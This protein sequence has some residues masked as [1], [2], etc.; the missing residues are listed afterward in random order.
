VVNPGVRSC[1]SGREPLLLSS[2][3]PCAT[4]KIALVNSESTFNDA[5]SEIQDAIAAADYDRAIALTDD[6][7]VSYPDALGA[8]RV[9]AS[10]FGASGRPFQAAE[11]YAR[12]LDIAP[13]DADAMSKMAMALSASGQ[14]AEAKL[15]ARQALDYEP[16]DAALQRII[17]LPGVEEADC[18]DVGVHLRAGLSDVRAGLLDRGIAR[19]SQAAAQ[20]PDRVDV[21]VALA[22]ALWQSGAQ[23]AAAEV[24]QAILDVQ[25][26]CLNAHA[27]L[28]AL[29]KS[30]GPSGLELLH[31]N[32]IAR[33]DPDHRYV[34]ALLGDSS[35]L[36]VRD[37]PAVRPLGFQ[38]ADAEAADRADWVADLVAAA[39]SA[40]TPLERGAPSFATPTASHSLEGDDVMIAAASQGAGE[41][42]VGDDVVHLDDAQATLAE[43]L[44]PL[45]WEGSEELLEASPAD[46]AAPPI[47]L[48]N[49]GAE[50]GG[51]AP[52]P[53]QR[54]I[55]DAADDAPAYIQPLEWEAENRLPAGRPAETVKTEPPATPSV[56]LRPAAGPAT[57]AAQ[58]AAAREAVGRGQWRK[59]VALYEKAILSSR[60]KV[61]DEV[62][63]DLETIRAVQPSVRAVYELLGMAYARKD[64]M[65]AALD[66]YHRAM[67]LAA[68]V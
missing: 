18:S 27:L 13:M 34:K 60:G 49:T 8:W 68:D 25:P 58:A 32:A 40:P 35:P 7:L 37:V 36:D 42:E 52:E 50:P 47:W 63:A 26:D 1:R 20:R 46:E 45:E 39:S 53:F 29:W 21:Q 14:Y 10:A 30:I 57:A 64:D 51:R 61:L 44:I 23:V 67:V 33:L 28:L 56:S 55:P 24:C 66:A 59:A 15:V 4:I 62:I 38:P 41:E 17:A 65:A 48:S 2:P 6:L 12:V 3:L 54:L 31:L 11:A 9:R 43:P 19:L 16:D 5:L 22:H